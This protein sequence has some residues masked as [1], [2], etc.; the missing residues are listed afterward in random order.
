MAVD[1]ADQQRSVP[2]EEM[3]VG[4]TCLP[5]RS[6]RPETVLHDRAPETDLELDPDTGSR[7]LWLQGTCSGAGGRRSGRGRVNLENGL[8]SPRHYWDLC[9]RK[10]SLGLFTL[11]R[12]TRTARLTFHLLGSSWKLLTWELKRQLGCMEG[13]NMSS[14]ST[15]SG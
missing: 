10:G 4:G 15:S 5:G 1:R 14:S 2:R 7:V 12:S 8:L 6:A 3:H 9:G 11:R 13:S